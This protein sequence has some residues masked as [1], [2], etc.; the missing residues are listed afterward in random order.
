MEKI[1]ADLYDPLPAGRYL[2]LL[3]ASTRDIHSLKEHFPSL[4]IL[5]R[6][7]MIISR[8]DDHALTTKGGHLY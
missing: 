6:S 4:D 5:L 1:A 2:L 3:L 7:P 8:V